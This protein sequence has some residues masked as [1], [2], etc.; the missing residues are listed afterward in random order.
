MSSVLRSVQTGLRNERSSDHFQ[1]VCQGCPNFLQR[2]PDL[3]IL[4]TLNAND[5]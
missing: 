1:K 5:L 3:V 4:K 2:G